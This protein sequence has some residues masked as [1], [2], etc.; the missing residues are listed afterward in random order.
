MRKIYGAQNTTAGVRRV[1]VSQLAENALDG[2][3]IPIRWER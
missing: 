1:T 3:G 2:D